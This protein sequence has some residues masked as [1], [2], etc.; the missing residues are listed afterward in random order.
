M[1]SAWRSIRGCGDDA[2]EEPDPVELAHEAERLLQ[3]PDSST[4]WVRLLPHSGQHQHALR[5]QHQNAKLRR[6]WQDP[7]LPGDLPGPKARTASNDPT[8]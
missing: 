5:L 8:G 7:G 2:T 3:W 4:L 1:P 6:A